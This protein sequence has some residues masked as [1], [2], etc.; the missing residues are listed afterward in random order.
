MGRSHCI[1]S[2]LACSLWLALTASAFAI[3]HFPESELLK[4]DPTH[5]DH[6]HQH[7]THDQGHKDHHPHHQHNHDFLAED[8]KSFEERISDIPLA[9]WLAGM[10]S[11][12]LISLVGLLA[13]GVLPLLAGPHQEA[14]LQLLVSLAVG[15]L[16]GDAL[17]HLL[18]HA[19]QAGHGDAGV[20]WKG[21]VAT[22]TIIAFFLLDR[23]L[24]AA[25]HSHC[26]THVH[27]GSDEEK[28]TSSTDTLP[29]FNQ[30]RKI[31][32]S[33][34]S[35]YH[36]YQRMEKDTRW[37]MPN[38]SLMVIVGDAIHNFAD[39]LAIGA[40]FSISM[41]AGL[42]TSIAVLCH[43]LPHEV[44][45]FALLF[46]SGMNVKV[47]IFYNCVSSIFAFIGLVVGLLIGTHGTF[48]TWLLAATV[49][50]FLYVSLVSMLTELKSSDMH[51]VILNTLGMISGAVL[52]LLIG[53][54]EHDLIL[55]FQENHHH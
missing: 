14:V 35:L 43:E 50:V 48:S 42:S 2:S 23:I 30:Q 17:I 45:D 46:H 19:L 9:V 28:V 51:K 4:K 38:S 12:G 21:F 34:Y 7:H 5:A 49:G 16:V 11:V 36:T 6:C 40:A 26:H 22:M 52:L 10:G 13:V 47:A 25:G 31:S 8:V 29:D 39:G 33:Y 1:L 41:A 18:P 37:S 20:V 32:T 15:T 54:Y 3:D 27:S 53:L 24:E 55:L 44:G